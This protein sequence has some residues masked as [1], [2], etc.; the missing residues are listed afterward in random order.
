MHATQSI[1][2][3]FIPHDI[4]IGPD[5]NIYAVELGA[6]LVHKLNN[7]GEL[8]ASWGASGSEAGQF[9]FSPPPD[10]PPLDGGFLVVGQGG[11]V[12]VSD[13]YNNRVQIFDSDGEFLEIWDSYGPEN[14]MFNNLGPISVDGNGSI[15]VADF[16]GLHHFDAQGNYVGTVGGAGEVAFDSQGN[17]YTTVA[18]EN[19]A[20]KIPAGGGEPHVWGEAGTEN[21]QFQ[22]PI[23]VVATEDSV[24]ISD[25]SGRVQKFDSQGNFISVWSGPSDGL[26]RFTGP[27]TIAQ[28]SQGNIYVSAKDRPTIYVIQP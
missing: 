2:L 21:G 5:G 27:A 1:D 12:Y 23:W 7:E 13:S 19:I 6:P 16:N 11:K 22:T 24:Y 3:P 20:M 10:G 17:L 9:A 14:T 18:F 25:H 8:L 15:F 28:D 26:G 4:A